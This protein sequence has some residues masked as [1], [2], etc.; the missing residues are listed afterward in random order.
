MGEYCVSQFVP[1]RWPHGESSHH[2]PLHQTGAARVCVWKEVRRRQCRAGENPV[3]QTPWGCE[4]SRPHPCERGQSPTAHT[5]MR[6]QELWCTC[7]VWGPRVRCALKHPCQG[8]G[9][10]QREVEQ[11]P[12]SSM[13]WC[14]G[15]DWV[16]TDVV[17]IYSQTSN[18][19]QI[20]L[21]SVINVN[22]KTIKALSS[23]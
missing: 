14:Q 10:G 20:F 4:L 5:R 2:H 19:S 13:C 11:S 12:K 15:G 9:A 8:P 7:M 3:L 16:P 23:P 22:H 17:L 18:I 1:Q 6:W 21:Y